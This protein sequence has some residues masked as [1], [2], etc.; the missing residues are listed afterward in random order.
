MAKTCVLEGLANPQLQGVLVGVKIAA[1]KLRPEPRAF[2]CCEG[3]G[4][5]EQGSELRRCDIRWRLQAVE[6]LLASVSRFYELKISPREVIAGLKLSAND[7]FFL[8]KCLQLTAL[9]RQRAIVLRQRAE[10][11]SP[12][13]A[14]A[15]AAI[16]RFG[17]DCQ[18]VVFGKYALQEFKTE[19][20]RPRLLLVDRVQGLSDPSQALELDLLISYA[21]HSGCYLGLALA[22]ASAPTPLKPGATSK[23]YFSRKIAVLKARPQLE[24]LSSSTRS[25]LENM[26]GGAKV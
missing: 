3:S 13:L 16:W 14:M 20:T 11:Q 6:R 19:G 2:A 25:R 23:D 5:C 26:C 4:L 8:K 22:E 15:L 18:L 12:L 1:Q 7:M 24:F 9:P 21:Y 17:I 10:E